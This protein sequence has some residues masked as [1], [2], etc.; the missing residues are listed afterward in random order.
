MNLTISKEHWSKLWKI[1]NLEQLH[2]GV[3]ATILL[4]QAIDEIDL[5]ELKAK[6]QSLR[7]GDVE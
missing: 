7:R 4:E 2:Y 6:K 1:C 3:M 5:E